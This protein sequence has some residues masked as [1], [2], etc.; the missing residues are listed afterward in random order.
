MRHTGNWKR[1]QSDR[2]RGVVF[3]D[4]VPNI[5]SAPG[6]TAQ[7]ALKV[8]GNRRRHSDEAAR[9]NPADGSDI[10]VAGERPF[11]G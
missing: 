9:T 5:A 6:V 1:L 4:R 7:T 10:G 11:N 8:L 3:S 2:Y